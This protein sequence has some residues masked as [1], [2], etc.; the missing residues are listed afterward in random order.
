[1]PAEHRHVS[2]IGYLA[3]FAALVLLAV[4][5]LAL[6]FADLE[7]WA[8][9]VAITIATIKALLVALVF[10]HLVEQPSA[11]SFVVLSA[12]A[13]VVL[14][15]GLVVADVETRPTKGATQDEGGSHERITPAPRAPGAESGTVRRSPPAGRPLGARRS[16]ETPDHRPR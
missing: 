5:S 15:V 12:V 4:L 16:F 9:P 10:M 13:L 2:L 7:A 8:M 3:T 14:L 6:S 1:M 11:N